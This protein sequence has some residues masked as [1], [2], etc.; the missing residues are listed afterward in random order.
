MRS[1][2]QAISFRQNQPEHLASIA[3]LFGLI[4]PS[5]KE[6][7]VLEL[8]CSMGG[9]LVTI[10]QGY[11]HAHCVGV[12]ASSRQIAE[13]WKSIDAL[14]FK[15]IQL[16]HADILEHGEDIGEFDYIISHGVYSW[17]P[18]SVQNKMLEICS[19][20]CHPTQSPTSATTPTPAGISAASCAT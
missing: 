7:R 2:I 15:N 14:G 18:A 3:G 10:A 17:V 13:G 20:I 12:D 16:K 6:W 11:P 9:N 4:A 5:P 8:G 19:N 1:L